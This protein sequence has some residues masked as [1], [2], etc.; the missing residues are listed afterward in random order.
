MYINMIKEELQVEEKYGEWVKRFMESWKNLD[1]KETVSLI[2]KE[3]KYYE[4]PIDEPCTSYEEVVKLWEVVEEN[5]KD[6]SYQY[7]I[8]AYNEKVCIINWQMER[9]FIPTNE[10]QSI[11]GIFEIS[12]DKSGLLSNFK[13]WRFTK[14]EKR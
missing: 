7:K 10:R 11:D 2:S 5:Q 3:V 4:N 12:L 14:V 9:T 1:W 13:Q 6:I 8:L